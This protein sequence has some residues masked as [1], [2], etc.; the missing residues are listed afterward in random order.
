MNSVKMHL[1]NVSELDDMHVFLP[2]LKYRP[3]FILNLLV[4]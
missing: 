1:F 4:A 2:D 3:P